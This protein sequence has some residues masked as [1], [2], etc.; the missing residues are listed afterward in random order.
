MNVAAGN[1]NTLTITDSTFTGSSQD[2]VEI[3]SGIVNFTDCTF[4]NNTRF[5]IYDNTAT[6]GT[7]T[8]CTMSGSG[9]G[10]RSRISGCSALTLVTCLIYESTNQNV[11]MENMTGTS[12]MTNCTIADA[13]ASVGNVYVDL[14]GAEVFPI[15]NCNI[16]GAKYGVNAA[17][18]VDPVVTYT[19]CYGASTSNYNSMTDP[20]GS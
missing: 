3:A 7:H 15:K 10:V 20:T 6:G 5:C 1:S 9:Y 14:A 17:G 4:S 19:N 8:R 2:A 18:A 13:G 11:Y 12:G 16:Y